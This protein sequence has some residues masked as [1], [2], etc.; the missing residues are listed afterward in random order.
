MCRR[1]FLNVKSEVR[2]WQSMKHR[3]QETLY[4]KTVEFTVIDV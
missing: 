1:Q 4:F 2:V 3:S